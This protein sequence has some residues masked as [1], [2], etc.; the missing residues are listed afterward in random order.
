MIYQSHQTHKEPTKQPPPTQIH[1][2][3]S[4]A[5]YQKEYTQGRPSS[6]NKK[7]RNVEKRLHPNREA[8]ARERSQLTV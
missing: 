3:P 8:R 2:K 7:D 5:K 6:G 1:P 4:I